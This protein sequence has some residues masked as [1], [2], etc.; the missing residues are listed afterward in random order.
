[1]S[2]LEEINSPQD[3]K[4]LTNQQLNQL[5][6]EI[7][8]YIV[9]T[10]S[11]TGGHLGPSLGVVEL[12]LAIHSVLDTPKDKLVWDVGHQAYPHKILTGRYKSFPTLRQYGGISGFPRREESPHDAF[13]TGHAGTSISAA[14]GYAI[15]RERSGDNYAVVAVIG[16]G[17]LTSGMSFEALNHA[18]ELGTNLVVIVNDNEMS[19]EQN[20]GALS[21]YLTRLRTDPTITKA[22][23]G[24]EN[25]MSKIPAIGGPV[26]KM[27]G[28]MEDTIKQILLPGAFFEELGFSYYGP[29]DGHNIPLMRRVI[30]EAVRKDYP[31]VIH[32]VTQKGRGYKP[33]EEDR[34]NLH[35]LKPQKLLNGTAESFPEYSDILGETLIEMIK[36]NPKIMA[37]T[38]AMASGTGLY[39]LE[40]EYKDHLLDVGIAE[41]HAVTLAAGLACGGLKPLVAIYSTFLQRSFDQIL[42]DVCLQNLDVTFAID[43]AGLVGDDGPTHHGCFDIAFLRTIPNTVI[44][45]PKD[46]AE[47]KLMLKTGLEYPG[48]AFIRYP[49]GSGVKVPLDI[50]LY[51]LPIGKGEVLRTGK[52][53]A[54][55]ALGPWAYTALEAAKDLVG[56]GID[57]AVINARYVKPLDYQLISDVA[58]NTGAILTIEEGTVMGGFGSAVLEYLN[59]TGLTEVKVKCLGIP[60]RFIEHGEVELLYQECGLTKEA[61]K[62]AVKSMLEEVQLAY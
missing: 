39:K 62:H 4:R 17:A 28:K 55:L 46:G 45:A 51:T 57:A 26:I 35:A 32:V 5:A 48:P 1:L 18:G 49:K 24:F 60:D 52:D 7:R 53:V 44:M 10:V 11:N 30:S 31:V 37:I 54:I 21:E 42:H 16:D 61:I 20:V 59:R 50:P 6:Q 34:N 3:I 38:A 14:L 23:S 41:E 29:I 19:I 40:D 33:A 47:L 13:G 2:V 56:E 15:A 22:R 36:T 9:E 8:E 25:I 12:T 58:G 27:K 43:R